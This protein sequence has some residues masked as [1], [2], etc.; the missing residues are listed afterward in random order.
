MKTA[1]FFLPLFILLVVSTR[2][3]STPFQQDE[4][5][6]AK[7]TFRNMTSYRAPDEKAFT[8][9]DKTANIPHDSSIYLSDKFVINRLKQ[10]AAS[11]KEYAKANHFNIDY[12]F[13]VDMSIPSG[14]KRFFI[15]NMKKDTVEYSS[16]VA[17]GAGSY[18]P[19]SDQLAFSNI[20]G[21]YKTSLGRYK[22]GHA[23]YGTYGLAY[24]LYG[25]DNTNNR[26]FE[27][28][29]VL[30][31]LDRVPDSET[32]PNN[33]CESAGCPMVSPAFLR[34]IGKY[35]TSSSNPILMWIYN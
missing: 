8:V 18:V 19:G 31:S 2:A 10:Q 28:A 25:L 13:L 6:L 35:I 12:C 14:K 20:P 34:I 11:L 3:N 7:E 9:D 1:T 16:L 30:H 23:Y 17:H 15:Y 5:G 21:S 26:A 32:Y 4:D 33:I 27:R 22:I 24:K 29:I